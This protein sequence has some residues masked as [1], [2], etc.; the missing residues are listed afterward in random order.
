[1]ELKNWTRLLV[2]FGVV[3][4]LMNIGKADTTTVIPQIKEIANQIRQ[5]YCP[6]NRVAV[7]SV[8]VTFQDNKYTLKGETD[9]REAFTALKDNIRKTL[10]SENIEFSIKVLPDDTMQGQNFGII[11]NSVESLRS[12]PS[13]Y[14]DQVTQ[15]LRG[16]TV[17]ILKHEDECYF[18][19]TDDG[20]LGWLDDD[21]VTVGG[22]ALK[23]TWL[24]TPKVVFDEIEGVIYSAA[25]KNSSPVADVVL[26][27][28]LKF[29]GKRG[30]WTAVEISDGR[31]GYIPSKQLVSEEVYLSRTPTAEN[32]I[33]TA[34]S[35]LGRP[36]VWGAASPKALDCSGL[37]QT[38]FRRNG[39]VLLRDAS[40]QVTQGQAVDMSNF[41]LNLKPGDCL[42]FGS[43]PG[44]IT[45][46]GIYLGNY[47]FIHCSG[48][49]KINSFRE[50]D[51]DFS[52]YLLKRLQQVKRFIPE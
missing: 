16:L 22:D 37:V 49:V 19:R 45:H 30:R 7:W 2:I 35:L 20:Y 47:Q 50:G 6:D 48:R 18:V 41:P 51:A 36:Y 28:R 15:T 9:N 40:M 43:I 12:G 21:R 4:T 11:I 3:I 27:N 38:S 46:T 32:V 42:F 17:E 5:Q 14:M 29:N 10:P 23:T 33:A 44:K 25:S 1:L 24:K 26:G 52:P 34:V 31:K 13:V 39:V 8:E